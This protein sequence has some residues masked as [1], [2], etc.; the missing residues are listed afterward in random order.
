MSASAPQLALV[1]NAR[2]AD[3]EF[4]VTGLDEPL[5][6]DGEYEAVMTHYETGY[7]FKTS[8]VFLHFRITTP[9]DYHGYSLYR[10]YRVKALKTKAGKSGGF[11]L[12]KRSDLLLMLVK[13]LGLN[14]RR[15][16]PSL[17]PLKGKLLRIRS[18]TVKTGSK[19]QPLPESLWYS[20]VDD[21]LN[22]AA[23]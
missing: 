22:V 11:T 23:G 8:K 7:V 5:I 19:Q 16:R 14:P 10:A 3:L 21:V 4:D 17:Q 2:A 1:R 13:V 12:N 18:R 9:G 6:P 20:V 15:D